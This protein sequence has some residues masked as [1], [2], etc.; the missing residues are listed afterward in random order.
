MW[1]E[2][3]DKQIIKPQEQ[4]KK[5]FSNNGGGKWKKKEEGPAELYKPFAFVSNPDMPESIKETLE[6]I[7]IKLSE[8]EYTVR[9]GGNK[10]LEEIFE[11]KVKRVELQLP[12]KG[13]NEKESKFTF[14]SENAKEISKAYSPVYD[15]L[16]DA[17]KVFLGR[18]VRL[19]LGK[20]LK[21]P[22]MFLIVWTA[23]GC[24]SA[25]DR[26]FR[27]GNAGHVIAMASAMRIPIFNISKQDSI[28]RLLKYLES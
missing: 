10:G 3:D 14:T 11:H 2:F 8:Q 26:T 21:S 5:F 27:T 7:A 4:K 20:D 9:L 13:F 25:R 23:D 17:V 12:W 24:E 28:N 18:N 16:P 6:M 22:A 15:K 19:L 1:D